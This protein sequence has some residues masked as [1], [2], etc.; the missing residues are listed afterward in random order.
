MKSFSILDRERQYL[1]EGGFTVMSEILE[2]GHFANFLADQSVLMPRVFWNDD[3]GEELV[4]DGHSMTMAAYRI[5][6]GG[7]LDRARNILDNDIL[8]GLETP[9]ISTAHIFDDL[10][11]TTPGYSFITDHRNPFHKHSRFLLDAML[12]SDTYGTRFFYAEHTNDSGISWNIDGIMKLFDV[13]GIFSGEIFGLFQFGSGQ[14]ARGTEICVMTLIN[15]VLHPRSV[16]WFDNLVNI[17]SLYNKVQTATDSQRLISRA[18]EPE[19]GQLFIRWN[20]F[21][22]PT[23]VCLARTALP[24]FNAAVRLRTLMFTSLKRKWTSDDL[25]SILSSI[26]APSVG[27]GGLGVSM[28]LAPVRHFLIAIT[29]RHFRGEVDRYG[30][31]EELLSHQAGHEMGIDDM[32]ALSMMSIRHVPETRLINFSRLSRL[33]HGMV[34]PSPNS[35]SP[36]STVAVSSAENVVRISRH[37]IQE[38][39]T[40][41]TRS[42]LAAQISELLAPRIQASV[43][44]GF[45]SVTPIGSWPTTTGADRVSERWSAILDSTSISP[46]RYKELRRLLANPNAAF[47]SKT[48][49]VVSQ[50]VAERT[51]DLLVI[52]P[53]GAGKTIPIMMAALNQSERDR[54]LVTL[55]IAP[56]L[57]L[58]SDLFKRMTA[59]GIRVV[60]WTD[61]K[62]GA[63]TTT[64]AVVL[65]NV[66]SAVSEAF[67][68]FARSLHK[69]KH[70]ARL[71]VDEVHYRLTAIHYRPLIQAL[72]H[73]RAIAAVPMLLLTASLPPSETQGLIEMLHL[74]TTSTVV[75]RQSVVRPNIRHSL[76]RLLKA[77]SGSCI[78]RFCD[79]AGE[80]W[81]IDQYIR[82]FNQKLSPR[83]RILVFCLYIKDVENLS[84]ALSCWFVH[85]KV[86]NRDKVLQQWMSGSGSR[87][88]VATCAISAGV[89]YSSVRMVL[90]WGAA[91]SMIDQD[92]EIG[93][94]GR[95]DEVAYS[96]VLWD[97]DARDFEGEEKAIPGE[98]EQTK[99]LESG[100]SQC[101]RRET[102]RYIDGCERSCLDMGIAVLCQICEK[103]SGV[104]RHSYLPRSDSLSYTERSGPFGYH[105]VFKVLYG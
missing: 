18:M 13:A 4:M 67:L 16:Y 69:L 28:G 95:D 41:L 27:E 48:Q 85:G 52:Q 79:D 60:K 47:K 38:L 37:D 99:W 74:S 57:A 50:L 23:L 6:Y 63:T 32:Y 91:R 75:I 21:V 94:A 45:A 25:S 36:T 83:D 86:T 26:S 84:N 35:P 55:M 51:R 31:A 61:M 98:R 29:K 2:I 49:A 65:V 40:G 54:G 105:L 14:P 30:F 59:A 44:E 64:A 56:L 80:V 9:D 97:P 8:L 72:C 76:Y 20:T 33:H 42:G 46:E 92:Q 43:A 5:M 77:E 1:T 11:N 58:V 70:L 89:D 104:L 73:I 87:I 15:T 82:D 7:L 90:H 93:R 102:C 100:T 68:T 78:A 66:D 24:R 53:T 34:R 101:L 17:V 22:I 81:R 12:D 10:A 3:E 19:A 103:V 62:D 71:V 96:V 39:I 88:L